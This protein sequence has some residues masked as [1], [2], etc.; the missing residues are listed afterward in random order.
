[1]TANW[2][3]YTIRLL[4]LAASG[5]AIYWAHRRTAKPKFD[6]AVVLITGG[7]RGLGLELAREWC[8]EG[9]RVAICA[10]TP[11]D[12]QRALADLHNS[13]VEAMA[14][15]CDVTSQSQVKQLVEHI[16]RRWG[17]IDVLVNNAGIIQV[18]PQPCMT[19]DDYEASLDTHFWGP[20]YT[21]E[22]VLPLMRHRGR[23]RIVNIASIGGKLS[24]P[25]LLPYCVGKFALV[26]LSEGL[27]AELAQ[28]GI[29]VT[30]VCPGLMRTGS[31]RNAFF[32]SQHR[33][34]Y[35]W[36]SISG[37]LPIVSVNSRRAARQI[38][39]ACWLGR[40]ELLITPTANITARLHSLFPETSIRMLGIVSRFL[41]G[42]GGVG[43]IN[44]AG[45]QSAST[46]SP[47]ALTRLTE[48]AAARNNEMR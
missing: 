16:L 45:E 34:E 29:L 38:V 47:S 21:I 22:Q 30:T 4:G 48:L 26:G 25:H 2:R 9:A 33:A 7:S 10:R 42:P 40:R 27:A 28:D 23:G 20:L 19:V 41:P 36:F 24:V 6:G 1:M 46:W 32:K 37:S 17:R 15:T 11:E 13:G 14:V 8:A 5:A 12:L 39:R 43:R 44:V 31:P 18:G 35:A 3:N